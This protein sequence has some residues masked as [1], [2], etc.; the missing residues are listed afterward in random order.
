MDWSDI[1]KGGAI[2]GAPMLLNSLFG[3]NDAGGDAMKFL[4]QIPGAMGKYLDPYINAGKGTMTDLQKQYQDLMNDPGSLLSKLGKGYQESP[5]FQFEKNQG[6]NSIGNAAAAGGMLGTMGHQ[7]QAGELAT[8]L[9][10]KDYG[11]YMKN[12]L[13]L[14]P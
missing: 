14:F 1:A 2:G 6:L 11:D 7:Q 5:G 10:N 9:A 12:A 8:N 3:G 4:D 13:M